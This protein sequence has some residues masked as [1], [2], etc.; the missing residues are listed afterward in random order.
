MPTVSGNTQPTSFELIQ[1]CLKRLHNKRVNAYY[2]TTTASKTGSPKQRL[3]AALLIEDTDTAD[4]C[5]LKFITFVS[6]IDPLPQSIYGIPVDDFDAL[7]VYKPQIT[8]FFEE[9]KTDAKTAKRKQHRIQTS[10]RLMDQ[11]SEN[12]TDAKIIEY[13]NAIKTQFP[14]T[15]KHQTGVN[16]YSYIDKPKGYQSIIASDTREHAKELLTKVLAIQGHTLDKSLLSESIYAEKDF[17]ASPTK[18]ILGV[19]YK[20]PKKR[21]TALVR[22]IRAEL[23]IH[24]KPDDILLYRGFSG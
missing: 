19:E 4:I 24:G 7:V 13:K 20:Q 2:T 12:I 16:K 14:A 21:P 11:T 22:L 6:L 9:T 8:L 23:K 15:Y 17:S 10:F 18:T 5:Q 3:K 1:N